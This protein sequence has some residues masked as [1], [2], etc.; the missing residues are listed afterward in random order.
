MFYPQAAV[1]EDVY[2]NIEKKDTLTQIDI[3]R[4]ARKVK[5]GQ[6]K[7]SSAAF[8][9]PA[10]PPPAFSF[11]LLAADRSSFRR[12]AE[13]EDLC[14]LCP[15][16]QPPPVFSFLSPLTSSTVLGCGLPSVIPGHHDPPPF[17]RSR[18]TACTRHALA[19]LGPNA[20]AGR[21]LQKF[22]RARYP[23]Y[24]TQSS[25]PHRSRLWFCPKIS[26]TAASLSTSPDFHFAKFP[27]R[28]P[29]AVGSEYA[30][31]SPGGI[32]A[33]STGKAAALQRPAEDKVP[34]VLKF[35]SSSHIQA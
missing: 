5:K 20:A 7:S 23:S 28:G 17:P 26:P 6:S 30:T 10:L 13:Q 15:L 27:W 21:S 18:R 2:V 8:F 31:G 11:L 9:F 4:C 35:K 34:P 22:H 14:R 33:R 32:A 3:I 29:F 19:L 16:A 1:Y 25:A 24:L 12:E